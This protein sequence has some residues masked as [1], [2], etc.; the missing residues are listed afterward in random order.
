MLKI[1]IPILIILIVFF[2]FRTRK[3]MSKIDNLFDKEKIKEM[4]DIKVKIQ[5]KLDDNKTIK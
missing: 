5:K 4:E 3:G 2:I 1:I